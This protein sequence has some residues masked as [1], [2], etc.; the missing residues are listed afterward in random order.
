MPS[1]IN[2]T[3]P[4][5]IKTNKRGSSPS[6]I[7]PPQPHVNITSSIPL[8]KNPPATTTPKFAAAKTT[9]HSSTQL[10]VSKSNG[11]LFASAESAVYI[12]ASNMSS[13]PLT[14]DLST[15]SESIS[16]LFPRR[17]NNLDV[18]QNTTSSRRKDLDL[19]TEEQSNTAMSNN[20]SFMIPIPLL[21]RDD[22]NPDDHAE[23]LTVSA[24][25]PSTTT[26]APSTAAAAP[27]AHQRVREESV[28]LVSFFRLVHNDHAARVSEP[29]RGFGGGRIL[30]GVGF[31]EC[32][33]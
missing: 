2:W 13:N 26:M 28:D 15:S 7:T 8:S 18:N 20:L 5:K 3:K 19:L 11:S 24:A 23:Q 29:V 31:V 12:S 25:P 21:F 30:E 9:A 17:K 33:K 14:K 1:Y 22:D 4:P 27:V 10:Q 32:R 16:P 6:I